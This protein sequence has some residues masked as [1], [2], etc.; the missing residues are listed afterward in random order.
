[1]L[2]GRSRTAS[3]LSTTW[4]VLLPGPSLAKLVA[5]PQGEIV[6]VNKAI[7]HEIVP[8]YFCGMD[9][10][11]SLGARSKEG[12]WNYTMWQ[13]LQR[14]KPR[15]WVDRT[16]LDDWRTRGFPNAEGWNYRHEPALPWVPWPLLKRSMFYAILGCLMHGAKTIHLYGCDFAGSRYFDNQSEHKDLVEERWKIE[17][18]RL[19]KLMDAAEEQ[20]IVIGRR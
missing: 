4:N 18:M 5:R 3:S 6:S 13:K 16:V 11:L 1:V 7:L 10:A 9:T 12:E 14:L 20:G 15:L 17:E 8:D 2:A 19:L